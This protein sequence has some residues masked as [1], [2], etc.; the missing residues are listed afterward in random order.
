M[1]REPRHSHSSRSTPPIWASSTGPK[2]R[3]LRS[4]RAVFSLFAKTMRARR[5]Q[6]EDGGAEL[7]AGPVVLRVGPTVAPL[8]SQTVK[9]FQSL[10][11]VLVE[12]PS[13]ALSLPTRPAVPVSAGAARYH[14][15]TPPRVPHLCPGGSSRRWRPKQHSSRQCGEREIESIRSTRQK[16]SGSP[17]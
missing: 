7:S 17:L 16:G 10:M 11:A 2:N 5:G 4:C 8:S 3:V 13:R 6:L 14:D 15:P 1:T 12:G 9:G